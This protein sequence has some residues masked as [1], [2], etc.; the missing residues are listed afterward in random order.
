MIEEY[1]ILIS[2]QSASIYLWIL[3]FESHVN[4]RHNMQ[5]FDKI[6]KVTELTSEIIF[7]QLILNAWSLKPF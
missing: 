1:T 7:R 3:C 4:K 5:K 2:D 6:Q